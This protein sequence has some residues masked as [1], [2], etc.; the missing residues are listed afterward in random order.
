MPTQILAQIVPDDT[1]PA[2]SS[3]TP[4]CTTCLV[5]GGTERGVNLFHSFRE[6]S[7][8]TGGEARFNNGSQIQNILTRVTGSNLSNIDGLLKTNGTANLFFLNP[9][10][11]VFGPNARLEI[12][13]SFLAATATSFKFPD[14]SEF[15][16]IQPEAPP[17]L[18]INIPLG[19]QPGPIAA[20]ASITNRGILHTGQNLTLN[21]DRLDLQ[22]RLQ[23]GA[24]L[25]L[26]ATHSVQIRDTATTPFTA[27]SGGHLNIHATQGI[28]ILAVNHPGQTPFVSGGDLNLSSNGILAIDA[29]FTSGGHVSIQSAGKNTPLGNSGSGNLESA[30]LGQ[31]ISRQDPIFN[32]AGNYNLALPYEGV[33]LQVNAGGNISYGEV[34]ITGIDPAVHPTNP[35][36]IFNAGGSITGTGTVQTTFPNGGLIVNFQSQGAINLLDDVSTNGGPITLKAVG[37]INLQGLFS[38]AVNTNGGNVN[39]ESTNGAIAISGPVN[40]FS[41]QRNSGAISIIA[42]EDIRLSD[43]VNAFSLATNPRGNG[44]NITIQSQAGSIFSDRDI[45]AFTNNGTGGTITLSAAKDITGTQLNTYSERGGNGGNLTVRTDSGNITL[46][47]IRTHS[48]NQTGGKVEL[49]N[50]NGNI[51]TGDIRT[52]DF[53]RSQGTGGEVRITAINGNLSTFNCADQDC[54]DINTAG[55]RTFNA[56]DVSLFATKGINTNNI[57][58]FSNRAGSPGKIDLTV[59]QGDIQAGQLFTYVDGQSGFSNGGNITLR[60]GAGNIQAG[61]A[62]SYSSIGNGGKV[63]VRTGQ[64][65]LILDDVISPYAGA[66]DRPFWGGDIQLVTSQGMIAAM[67]LSAFAAGTGSG[68]NV[69]VFANG[70][71]LELYGVFS[72]SGEGT[73]GNIQLTTTGNI[74]TNTIN[75]TGKLGSGSIQMQAGADYTARIKERDFN[76]GLYSAVIASDT[77]GP[78]TGGDISI[79]ARSIFLPQGAQ[80]SSSTHSSGQGGNIT[81]EA[82]ERIEI[83]GLIPNG[84]RPGTEA[85]IGLAGRPEGTYWGGYIP[86][87]D[88]RRLDTATQYPA[89]VYTQTTT[90]S[91]GRAGNIGIETPHLT[92]QEG[93]AIAATTFG[94]GKAGNI[95][96]NTH[97]ERGLGGKV[98]LNQGSINSGVFGS[99]ADS[100]T[101]TLKTGILEILSGG[102]IQTQTLGRGNAG[103]IQIDASDGVFLRNPGSRIRSDSGD[104]LIPDNQFGRGGDIRIATQQFQIV[105]SAT[106]SAQT[107]TAS[108]GGTIF[109]QADSFEAGSRGQLRTTTTNSGQ[110]G[111]IVLNIRDRL[112]LSDSGTG[113]FAD[114]ELGST[115]KGGSIVI[116]PQTILIQDGAGIAVDSFG[117]GQGGNLQIQAGTITLDNRG[118]LTAETASAQGGNIKLDVANLLFL[119]RNSLI[120]ATA[121]TAQA[122]GDGGNI[123][124]TAPFVI[125]VLSENSDIRANAFTGKGG[126]VTI[127]AHGIFGLRFQ[128]KDT[129]FSDITASSQ[130]GLSGTVTLNL[131]NVDPSRGLVALPIN[132][133]E[134]SQQIAQQ[135]NPKNRSSSFV[136]TGRGGIPLSPEQIVQTQVLLP[137]WAVLPGET[138][139]GKESQNQL[140]KQSSY[141]LSGAMHQ[142]SQSSSQSS[143]PIVEAKEWIVDDKGIVHLVAHSSDRVVHPASLNSN[144]CP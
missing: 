60:T 67:D 42:K 113:L 141:P 23:S 143:V 107:F 94:Q 121:G 122:G 51:T 110:A 91:S 20:N 95:T 34:T 57:N 1:L 87:G 133:V 16:A 47:N 125:G 73:A 63:E 129:P 104:A 83:S 123:T 77:F 32:V 43:V 131:L 17:L 124:I 61:L 93:G 49:F 37:D 105:D 70:G 21:A 64:G 68:G 10:G 59:I 58:A 31:V 109:V 90:R 108:Q 101:I 62:L 79:S 98:L 86:S 80:V 18:T 3:V 4:G 25:T 14:G 132:L 36:L 13:G 115:G 39:L 35:A 11:I 6:F 27:Q 84:V 112:T 126:N 12:G 117:S 46:G 96:I 138:M 106:L 137:E 66:S 78:G 92:V 120:S 15:S 30:S 54:G 2:N 136:I 114:T 72:F 74:A 5:N 119:R 24:D 111:N 97:D 128:P 40:A 139:G 88:N 116:D 118:F 69:Q 53:F 142:S 130:F 135:C 71:D 26:D 9:N 33:S 134:P 81:L 140:D 127:T 144:F 45:S 38:L 89:G 48:I 76:R 28:D 50:G 103:T 19:L 85:L 7:V 100:G 56:K 65:N 55:R 102:L 99:N 41:I 75:S 22:G 52:A 8:P 82:S 44:N 29:H